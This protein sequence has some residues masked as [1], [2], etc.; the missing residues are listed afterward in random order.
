MM[1][2]TEKDVRT[3]ERKLHNAKFVPGISFAHS[4]RPSGNGFVM[5]K[6]TSCYEEC[7]RVEPT[8]LDWVNSGVSVKTN[9]EEVT[10]TPVITDDASSIAGKNNLDIANS[11]QDNVLSHATEAGG[12]ENGISSSAQQENIGDDNQEKIWR[13]NPVQPVIPDNPSDRRNPC[14]P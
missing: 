14:N 9:V 8:C 6:S 3:A 2:V 7:C 13:M 5:M 1:H 4:L 10:Q 11:S 12:L